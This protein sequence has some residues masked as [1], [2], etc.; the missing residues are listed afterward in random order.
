MREQVRQILGVAL[1]GGSVFSKQPI[2]V[3]QGLVSALGFIV[4]LTAW[5]GAGALSNLALAYVVTGAW[6]Q[7]SNVVA[8]VVGYSKFGGELDRLTASPIKPHTYLLGLLLGTSPFMLEGLLPAFFLFYITGYTPIKVFEEVVLLAPASL[9]AGSFFS[10]A[11]VLNIKNPTN[12][13][14]ITNPLY[15]LTVVLPPVYYPLSFLPGWLR[16]VSLCDPAVSLLQVGRILAGYSEPLN[17]N[18]VVLSAALSVTVVL[19]LSFKSF[20]WGM[21]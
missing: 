14:A 20:R 7:G 13:S 16:L 10:L 5:G 9:V 15:T 18:Y 21:R 17:P 1:L 6:G 19:L 4:T 11:I 3:V 8:Q 2:W 12:V